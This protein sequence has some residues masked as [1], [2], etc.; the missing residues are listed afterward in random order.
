MTIWKFYLI[1]I[2]ECISL[3]LSLS[4]TYALTIILTTNYD[5]QNENQWEKSP[6]NGLNL[7]G[8]FIMA[9]QIKPKPNKWPNCSRNLLIFQFFVLSCRVIYYDCNCVSCR[10]SS[11]IFIFNISK[12]VAI[13]L[14]FVIFISTHLAH[15]IAPKIVANAFIVRSKSDDYL[16]V[17]LSKWLLSYCYFNW[18]N[19]R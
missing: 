6:L 7:I 11:N 19:G 3:Y 4:L 1:E 16:F 17:L 8:D 13:N 5:I 12:D 14:F 9:K 15:R 18:I 2:C 10:L